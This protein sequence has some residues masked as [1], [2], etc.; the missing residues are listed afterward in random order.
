MR[1]TYLG[2]DSSLARGLESHSNLEGIVDPPLETGEGT[3]HENTGAKAGPE[4]VEANASVDGTSGFTGLVHD[5]DHGVGGVRDDSAEDTSPVTGH[6]GN[7][8]LLA[9]GVGVAGSGEDVGV[10]E[11]DGLLESDELHDSVGDLA[12]PE[13]DNTLVEQR[14]ATFVH[15]LGETSAGSGG[16]SSGVRSLDLDLESFHGA[17]SDIGNEL[18]G[19]RGK[20]ETNS[21]VL[22]GVLG[23]SGHAENILEHLVETELAEALG[24]VSDESGEP[25]L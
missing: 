16:E 7:S 10:Q 19:G 23:A 12:A 1:F 15:H 11:T 25:T 14:P 20:G 13:R 5:G 18:S 4:T 6:E 9:L 17:E 21:L 3:N 22:D 24:T 2:G 8:E